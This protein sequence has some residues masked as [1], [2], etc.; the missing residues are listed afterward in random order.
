MINIF[1][2]SLS[3]PKEKEI[4]SPVSDRG[5]E[6]AVAI[7]VG[8]Y[9]PQVDLT[10]AIRTESELIER[11]R[12]MSLYPEVDNAIDDIVN[13]AIN[14]EDDEAT[15]TLHL[16]K[17]DELGLTSKVKD[18]INKE[19]KNILYLLD[20]DNRGYEFFRQWYIDG[21]ILFLIVIDKENP[22][23]GI[24]KLQ[25]MD[26]TKTR[27]VE[28]VIKD[29]KNNT[30]KINEYYLYNESGFGQTDVINKINSKKDDVKITKDSVV[31][32]TS[33]LYTKNRDMVLS[34]LHKAY[35]VL[36]QLRML[37]DASVIYRL[38]R[39]PE[40]R[41]FYIDVGGLPKA[42]AEQHVK[43][44]MTNFKNKVAYDPSN[45]TVR[46]ERKFMAMNE[47][48][49]FPRRNDNRATQIETLP[50]G[51]NLGE[52]TDV[53]YFNE[54]LLKSLNV[55]ISRMQ[56]DNGFSLGRASEISRD[57][58]KFAKFVSRL[59]NKFAKIFYDLLE[60]QLILKNIISSEDWEEIRKRIK[61]VFAN[62]N[63]FDELKDAEIEKDRLSLLDQIEPYVGKYYSKTYVNRKIL[64]LSEED[65]KTM[66]E[67]MEEEF[68][69]QPDSV[70]SETE[71]NK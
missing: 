17:L 49:W 22:I 51:A 53:N 8:G 20:F 34:Y 50:A 10:S 24:K 21:R 46:D 54:K 7:D 31:I 64:R 69:E 29:K 4:A 67:E 28:E 45:G 18:E 15:V 16:D 26:P 71:I 57:E 63:Y 23:E 35:K 48:F 12:E 38:V 11:Y 19:F 33:G 1:G 36:N 58:L 14:F 3:R 47:D 25:Y 39:A 41:I 42:K 44:M 9:A 37:E 59:R 52:M 40:R 2:Y 62:D 32:S 65:L 5:E 43:Q 61:I 68:E 66:Q 60:Q 13:E 6:G 30:K 56:S 55:P 27:K 70:D